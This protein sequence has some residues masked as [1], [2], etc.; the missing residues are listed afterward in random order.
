M[1]QPAELKSTEKLLWSPGCGTDLWKLF[2]ACIDGN[3]YL[4]AARVGYETRARGNRETPLLDASW[5]QTPART[6]IDP[7]AASKPRNDD[8]R[9]G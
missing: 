6:R 9:E 8:R 1:R 7:L 3:L 2:Q 5:L 4:G